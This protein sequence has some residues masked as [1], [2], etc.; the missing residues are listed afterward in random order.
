MINDYDSEYIDF[1][2]SRKFNED[3]RRFNEITNHTKKCKCGHSV[4]MNK[5]VDKVLCTWCKNYVFKDK[6][7]EDLYRLKERLK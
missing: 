2:K 5:G 7:T 6:K 1:T 3:T 4:L